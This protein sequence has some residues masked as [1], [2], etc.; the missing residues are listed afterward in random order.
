M[1]AV[2]DGASLPS[3]RGHSNDELNDIALNAAKAPLSNE[4]RP[5]SSVHERGGLV[6]PKGSCSSL[7]CREQRT[8]SALALPWACNPVFASDWTS[9]SW[10]LD[11][12]RDVADTGDS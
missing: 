5:H 6:P 1:S 4:S 12:D 2:L 10:P 8:S 9:A 11:C 7:T 3:V